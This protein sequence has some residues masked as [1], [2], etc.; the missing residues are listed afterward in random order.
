MSSENTNVK[1]HDH[2]SLAQL[3]CFSSH[4]ERKIFASLLHKN[5]KAPYIQ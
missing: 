2:E 5:H 4:A 3:L 1:Q